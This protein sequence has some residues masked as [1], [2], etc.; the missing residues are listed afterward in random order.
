MRFCLSVSAA[1]LVCVRSAGNPAPQNACHRD[2]LDAQV[3]PGQALLNTRQTCVRVWLGPL[4]IVPSRP[5]NRLGFLF[6]PL[7]PCSS[8]KCAYGAPVCEGMARVER[9]PS[10]LNECLQVALIAN[11]GRCNSAP[12]KQGRL[13][14][15]NHWPRLFKLRSDRS[16]GRA[17]NADHPQTLL[18]GGLCSLLALRNMPPRRN[19]IPSM[20]DCAIKVLPFVATVAK[21]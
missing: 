17:A 1:D 2:S 8:R 15:G 9:Q 6:S 3:H 21:G 18:G 14:S 7:E 12:R 10:P 19:R 5:K 13:G 11:A 20:P 4:R 16:D